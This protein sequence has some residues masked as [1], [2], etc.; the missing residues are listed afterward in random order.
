MKRLAIVGRGTAGCYAATFFLKR[1]DWNI[2]WYFDE[3]IK[4]QT[5]G[6][7]SLP[8]FPHDLHQNI[9]FDYTDLVKVDGTPKLGIHKKNW[10]SGCDYKHNFG[11]PTISYH[12]NAV[13]L[14]DYITDLLRSNPRVN[15]INRNVTHDEIDADY[16]M[17]CSGK[18]KS[19]D[20]FHVSEYIPVNS[21]H[22]TPCYWDH[23]R[24]THT[25]T[26]ARPY[27][28]IFGIPLVNRCSIG[29][30]FNNNYATLDQIK[31]DVKEVFSEFGL[32]PSEDTNTFSFGNYY[33]KENFTDRVA[34]NGNASFFLEPL[35]A[36]SI[37]MMRNVVM[38]AYSQ[39][40]DNVTPYASNMT[41][42]TQINEIQTQIMF[43]YCS[44][45]KYDTEFW[46]FA[47]DRGRRC[48]REALKNPHLNKIID[49]SREMTYDNIIPCNP[50][51]IWTPYDFKQ[52]FTNLGL[53]DI[54]DEIRR[55]G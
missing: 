41:Y 31:E 21:V 7:G 50:Y 52:N 28:W 27:G 4:P 49:I 17:D 8:V 30:M 32:T 3:S 48:V 34:Y 22:V 11:P 55:V 36:T 2:D 16:I 26:I 37:V 19:Y 24:L 38:S 5:V 18:P 42:D 6:E 33:R 40:T 43:H 53:Y 15:M 46:K 12:F 39:W 14:Q 44:G 51:S 45:S 9:G 25:L 20:D 1:T 47:Q 29:Y 13:K 10:G 54:V 35:D 23:C